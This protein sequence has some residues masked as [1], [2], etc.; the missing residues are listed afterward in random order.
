MRDRFFYRPLTK[1]AGF[2]LIELLVIIS[3]IGVMSAAVLAAVNVGRAKARNA[4]RIADKKQII[5]ALNLYYTSN[6]STWPDSAGNWRCLG[7]AAETCWLGTY[8]G[9]ASLV[10]A[11]STYVPILPKSGAFSGNRA[12]D[13]MIYHSNTT[14]GTQTGAFLVWAHEGP[15]PAG[16]C[17]S[18]YA[19]QT[20]DLYTYCYEYLGR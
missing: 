2:T 9:L 16:Q 3:I 6:N 17:Q 20:Y 8:S 14:T 11:L 19:P 18:A 12:Y 1:Q 15:I 7:P 4:R 10:T 13:R 5:T